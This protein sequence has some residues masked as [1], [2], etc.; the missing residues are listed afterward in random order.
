MYFVYSLLI[1]KIHIYSIV[2]YVAGIVFQSSS[3]CSGYNSNFQAVLLSST[4][5]VFALIRVIV[6]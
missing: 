3:V 6:L 2:K 5:S 1:Y 4:K